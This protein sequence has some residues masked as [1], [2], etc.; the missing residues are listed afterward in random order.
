MKTGISNRLFMLFLTVFLGSLAYQVAA[1]KITRRMKE[2]LPRILNLKS[3]GI[4]GENNQGYLA[5]IKKD[6]V[7]QKLV[8]AENSDRQKAYKKIA[9]LQKTSLRVVEQL[10]AKQIAA[11][12]KKGD[13]L[14][15]SDGK[16]YQ[17]K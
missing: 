10:R 13:W 11:K 12:A 17:K 1:D 16:W 3:K 8:N 5:F 15:S 7:Y 9:A 6:P 2:R 14:Q 4:V